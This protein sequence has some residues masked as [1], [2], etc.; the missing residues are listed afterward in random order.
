[1]AITDEPTAVP[2]E[3]SPV[4]DISWIESLATTWKSV[5]DVVILLFA[6]MMTLLVWSDVE[7]CA[8]TPMLISELKALISILPVEYWVIPPTPLSNLIPPVVL[9]ALIKMEALQDLKNLK[10]SNGN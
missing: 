10:I 6:S 7:P 1:M 5:L 4:R 2:I 3:I 8:N 9:E